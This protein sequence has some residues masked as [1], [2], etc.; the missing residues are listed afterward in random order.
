MSTGHI[1]GGAGEVP[2]DL[3][4]ELGEQAFGTRLRR[5]VDRMMRDVSR[6][7]AALGVDFESRWFPTLYLLGRHSPLSITQIARALGLTHPAIN[8]VTTAMAKR[9][10]LTSWKDKTDE[11]RRF[12]ELSAKGRETIRVLTP[13]WD[14]ITESTRELLAESNTDL[15]SQIARLEEALNRKS[16]FERVID[17]LKR[18]QRS[19][20]EIIDYQPRLKG[21]FRTLNTEWLER[22]FKVEPPDESLLSDPNGQIL[23]RGG[24]VLFA[25]LEGAIVG[26]AALLR[27]DA[28][29]YE[30]AKMAVTQS[31]QG[32]QVGRCLANAILA[33]A[34]KKRAKTLILHTSPLLKAAN[35]LY[36]SLGFVDASPDPVVDEQYE[37]ETFTMTLDLV[38]KPIKPRA[39]EV[40]KE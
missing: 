28:D 31:A 32:K 22:Y 27:R 10:L 36:R 20:V 7:Y 2:A 15:M 12:V 6:V 1:E 13:V 5:L 18:E 33:K 16:V 3:V 9:G 39:G 30:L 19:Q 8:Q 14:T 24:V 40:M 25:R 11:R 29:T 34:R 23:K 37:R 38:E 4:A 26:T 35:S 17:S 21:H